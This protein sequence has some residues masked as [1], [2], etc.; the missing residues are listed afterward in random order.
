MINSA[1]IKSLR[2]WKRI[3]RVGQPGDLRR[4]HVLGDRTRVSQAATVSVQTRKYLCELRWGGRLRES[5][6]RAVMSAMACVGGGR[7]NS[8]PKVF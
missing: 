5:G 4:R 1:G 2:K 6:R 3:L 8:N 7:W